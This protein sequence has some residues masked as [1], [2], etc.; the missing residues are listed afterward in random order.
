MA[1]TVALSEVGNISFIERLLQLGGQVEVTVLGLAHGIAIENGQIEAATMLI[2][3]GADMNQ[4]IYHSI[5]PLMMALIRRDAAL[6]HLLLEAD[7]L[8]DNP[9]HHAKKLSTV[10]EWGHLS[11]VETLIHAGVAVNGP[12]ERR[13]TAYSR[14]E[15][16]RSC[17][18]IIW[19]H[20]YLVP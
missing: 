6:V 2:D 20:I 14:R 5:T 18:G 16:V 3:A 7:A 15:A 10:V 19:F 4:C 13:R 9:E 11:I 12:G 17:I 8:P 1:A